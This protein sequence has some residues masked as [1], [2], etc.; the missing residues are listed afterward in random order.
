M[1]LKPPRPM[2][3]TVSNPFKAIARI[4]GR[5]SPE[6]T[7]G[8]RYQWKA[9]AV[10]G[11]YLLDLDGEGVEQVINDSERGRRITLDVQESRLPTFNEPIQH[12]LNPGDV[13]QLQWPGIPGDDCPHVK[14][15]AR[16]PE[17]AKKALEKLRKE[18]KKSW[19]QR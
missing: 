3:E 2:T 16:R 7:E 4:E 17:D 13:I 8:S 19:R 10:D 6:D 1:T 9:Y 15:K 14:Q 18:Q 11:S 5:F 12:V